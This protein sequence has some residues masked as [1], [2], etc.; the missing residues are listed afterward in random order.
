MIYDLACQERMKIRK[1]YSPHH[2]STVKK[3]VKSDDYKNNA[4]QFL[5]LS[6]VLW[7]IKLFVIIAMYR[8]IEWPYTVV[9][10]FRD[11]DMIVL[12]SK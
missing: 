10:E 6:R 9:A 11:D 2:F 7:I 12:N 4:V 1:K 8:M 5:T 3:T